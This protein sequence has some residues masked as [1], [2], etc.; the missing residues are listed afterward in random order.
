M[1]LAS[2]EI[3]NDTSNLR[4]A[5]AASAS[6]LSVTKEESKKRI[7]E[8]KSEE[9]RRQLEAKKAELLAIQKENEELLKRQEEELKQSKIS[10][11]RAQFDALCEKT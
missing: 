11:D 4:I 6:P 3:Q 5:P 9:I 8:N 7:K 1:L 2:P 10:I